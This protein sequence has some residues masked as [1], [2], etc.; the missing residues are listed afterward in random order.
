M[1]EKMALKN[2]LYENIVYSYR[3]I[4]I[5]II[6][7]KNFNFLTVFIQQKIKF[8]ETKFEFDKLMKDLTSVRYI[9][10]GLS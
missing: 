10:F 1:L 2:Y 8:F 3:N 7:K 6:I 4:I 9:M 5:H